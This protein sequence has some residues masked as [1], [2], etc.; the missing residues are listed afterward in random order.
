MRVGEKS[1]A[2]EEREWVYE[3]GV[4]VYETDNA[5][6]FVRCANTGRLLG[7]AEIAVDEDHERELRL[8]GWAP[9]EEI[10]PRARFYCFLR[11]ELYIKRPTQGQGERK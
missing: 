2:Q 4:Y 7:R 1:L 8:S 3:G 5:A 9:V 10:Y 11:E 6:F